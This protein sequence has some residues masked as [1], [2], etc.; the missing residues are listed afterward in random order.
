MKRTILLLALAAAAAMCWVAA[1]S[2]ASLQNGDFETGDTSGWT[3]STDIGSVDVT[4]GVDDGSDT[5]QFAVV[6]AGNQDAWQSLSQTFSVTAGQT[7]HL[8]AAF[9]GTEDPSDSCFGPYDDQ[10]QVTV[11]DGVT[12]TTL[13]STDAC[14]TIGFGGWQLLSYTATATGDITVTA[15]VRNIGD[16]DVPSQ[17][18]L[19]N[20]GFG[21]ISVAPQV[22]N[23]FL[24]YSSF[25]T[26][27]GVWPANEALTLV[28]QGYWEP[29]AVDGNV[30]GGVNVGSYHLQCNATPKGDGY[31][32]DGGQW[33]GP[34]WAATAKEEL[35]F[36]PH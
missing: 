29:T 35:G 21:A 17:I 14:S 22:N 36:Y 30:D 6:T 26:V 5:S 11:S 28:K 16:A 27:P 8:Q 4:T 1:A 18:F 34:E 15:E 20:V 25:Q 23:I 13:Y 32:G 3:T 12:T 2:A 9:N 7:V 19:D 33:F 31:V 10:G 24:C